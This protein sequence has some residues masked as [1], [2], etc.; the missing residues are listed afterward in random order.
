MTAMPIRA[1]RV[2]VEPTQ[3][4]AVDVRAAVALHVAATIL[5]ECAPLDVRETVRGNWFNA[6]I[7]IMDAAENWALAYVPGIDHSDNEVYAVHLPTGSVFG[8]DDHP[9]ALCYRESTA[10]WLDRLGLNIPVGATRA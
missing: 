5:P 10:A 8:G 7:P 2:D 9:T 4:T 3:F 1:L 6:L